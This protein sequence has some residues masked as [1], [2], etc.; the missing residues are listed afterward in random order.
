MQAVAGLVPKSNCVADIG[1]DHGYVSIFLVQ[2]G[3]AGRA[4]AMD[5][6]KGPLERAREHVTAHRLESYIELRLSDGLEK[7]R[8]GEADA[9]VI[10]GMGGATMQQILEQGR[11]VLL[12]GM[13][14]ALQPQSELLEFRRY[15]M[16]Q[17][18]VFKREDM[19]LEDGKYYPMMQVEAP[20]VWGR[21]SSDYPMEELMFGPLLLQQ[22]HPVLLE[23]LEW[24]LGQVEEIYRKVQANATGE[25]APKR[26]TQLETELAAIGVG[27]G[28]YKKS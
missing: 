8:P 4:I 12:P 21:Q 11:R 17:G 3:I 28:C 10:A 23:F 27:L 24:R 13:P 9:I 19:V 2:Q 16:E 14:L 22:H 5:V 26:L 18:F 7:L 6:R 15:L 1:C 25:V 20:E